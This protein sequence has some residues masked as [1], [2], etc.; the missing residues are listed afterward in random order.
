MKRKEQRLL[1]K[2]KIEPVTALTRTQ[3][4]FYP[5][6]QER[7]NEMED[8]RN[9]SYTVYNCSALLEMGITKNICG[10]SSMQ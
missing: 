1:K 5:S 8:P 9:K 4:Y 6:F 7:L 10:I 3:K 2:L